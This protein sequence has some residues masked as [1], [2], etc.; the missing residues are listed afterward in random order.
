MD[1]QSEIFAYETEETSYV[2]KEKYIYSPILV[3]DGKSELIQDHC[4]RY[5]RH[6]NENLKWG[7]SLGPTTNT[8]WAGGNL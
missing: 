5:R 4:N 2:V 1:S 3:K 8:A 6:G 7:E